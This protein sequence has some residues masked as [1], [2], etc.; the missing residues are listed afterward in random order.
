MSTTRVAVILAAGIGSRLRPLTDDRPKALVSV[1]DGTILSRAVDA[2]AGA[3][4]E[5]LVVASGYREDALRRA[6]TNAPFEVIYRANPRYDSTQNSVSLALCRDAL[7]G[8]AFYR[9]D[10]DVVFDPEILARL[11]AEPASIATMVDFERHL[12]EEAMKVEIGAGSRTIRAF[13]KGI[14]LS[15]SA[16]ESIGIERI[17]GAAAKPLFDALDSAVNAGETQLYYEDVY[18]RLI[19]AGM[20]AVAIDVRGLRWCEIDSAEDLEHART[21][22]RT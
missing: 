10:G 5:R 2:L 20:D 4:V 8:E 9:L 1:G 7:E 16:G 12:D 6:L 11:D 14:P 17:S 13:G 15:R 18:S 21:L 3:G 19:A 22:F